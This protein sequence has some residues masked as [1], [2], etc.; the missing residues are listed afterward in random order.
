MDLKK[1][2]LSTYYQITKKC[3]LAIHLLHKKAIGVVLIPRILQKLYVLT[4]YS[5]LLRCILLLNVYCTLYK[6][7]INLSKKSFKCILDRLYTIMKLLSII[8]LKVLFLQFPK[9]VWI[10]YL[11]L[12]TDIFLKN[13]VRFVRLSFR[14]LSIDSQFDKLIHLYLSIFFP[15]VLRWLYYPR[16]HF[17]LPLE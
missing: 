2:E 5:I 11:T 12:V 13:I 15:C 9:A 14:H 6:A 7:T 8:K 4:Y 10:L 3:A 17:F 16:G 1:K